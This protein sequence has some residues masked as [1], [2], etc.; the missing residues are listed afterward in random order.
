LPTCQNQSITQRSFVLPAAPAEPTEEARRT[1][2]GL[3][4][5][6]LGWAQSGRRR[7]AASRTAG[8]C[9][10]PGAAARLEGPC[11]A[12]QGVSEPLAFLLSQNVIKSW[13]KKKYWKAYAQR[14]IYGLRCPQFCKHFHQLGQNNSIFLTTINE[15]F[16]EF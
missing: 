13:E 9:R 2:P 12:S 10:I 3:L 8:G 5:A 4:P 1:S 16:Y 11:P 6:R 7:S 14:Y 15:L